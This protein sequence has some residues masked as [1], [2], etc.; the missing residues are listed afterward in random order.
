[1]KKS[2]IIIGV[3]GVDPFGS[4][5]D[6]TVQGEIVKGRRI[7]V[8]RYRKVGEI[9]DCH[10]LF[11]SSSEA[12]KVSSILASLKGRSI[13]TVSDAEGFASAGGMIRF[14]TDKNKI[15]FRINTDATKA[16]NLSISS[17][18]LQLAEIVDAE[19]RP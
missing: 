8:R 12:S 17:K 19:K 10:I 16:A 15:R 7:E 11:I 13:L 2:P 14:I 5:L 6:E 18:L 4:V 9:S 3:L 1:M